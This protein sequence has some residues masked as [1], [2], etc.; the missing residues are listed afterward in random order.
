MS[1][2][3]NSI[4]VGQQIAPNFTDDIFA[5]FDPIYGIGGLREVADLTER[6]NISAERLRVGMLVYVTSE[7]QFYR[8]VSFS[9]NQNPPYN[10]LTNWENVI[11][12]N[13]NAQTIS[14]VK[15]F[16]SRPTV[17]GTG[18]LLSGEVAA[19][20]TT[21]V[22]TTGD[23]TIS[24]IKTLISPLSAPN[25][26]YN[27]GAQTISGTKTFASRPKVNGTGVLLSGEFVALPTTIVYTTGDQTI[28][29]VKTFDSRP[30]INGTGVL[31]SGENTVLPS[32]IVYTTGDQS[33]SGVKTFA[34]RPT[35]N[36][37]GVLLSGEAAVLPSTIVYTTGDQSISGVKTFAS[38]PTVNG[39]GVLLSGE[40]AVL[41]STIVYTTG[42]QS[43]SGAKTFIDKISL[44]GGGYI[45]GYAT[46]GGPGTEGGLLITSPTLGGSTEINII[47]GQGSINLS[48]DYGIGISHAGGINLTN[49]QSSIN[50]P[51]GGG[52]DLNGITTAKTGTF[53]KLYAGNLV[54]N[55]GDQ[56]I[57]GNKFF[58]NDITI[59]NLTVTGTRTIT[60]TQESNIQSNYLL[61]NITGGVTNGGIYFVTGAGFSGINSSGPIIAYDSDINKFRIGTGIRSTNINSLKTIAAVE[62][63]VTLVGNQT[64]SG[65]KTFSASHYYPYP[66]EPSSLGISIY[67]SGQGSIFG[68]L[69]KTNDILTIA[70]SNTN[71]KIHFDDESVYIEAGGG[72]PN[73]EV[74][75]NG[76]IFL[77]ASELI[78]LDGQTAGK[79]GTFE[80]LY[81]GNLVYNTGD[82][83][84]S[85]NKTFASRP[86]VNGTGFLLSGE[87]A[88]SNQIL[89]TTY[90]ILTGLKATN[91]LLSGQRYRISDF[92]LKWNNQSINDQTVKT[93]ASGE[94][95]IVTAL[96]NKEI[97]Y[98][99]QS[100][101]YP[102]DT[103]YY[104]INA[105]GSYSWG[106]INNNASIPNFKGWIYRRVDNLLDIDIAYDWRNITVNCCKPDVNSI[107]NYSGNYNYNYPYGLVFVKSTGDDSN[108]GK[109]YYSYVTGNSGNALTNTNFWNPVSNFVESGTYF[110]TDESYGFKSLWDFRLGSFCISLSPITGSR[111]QQ[112]TFTSV[113]TGLGLFKLKDVT[114]IKILGGCNNVI[115]GDGFNSNIIGTGFSFNTIKNTVSSNII[116]DNFNANTIGSNFNFNTIGNNFASN[117]TSSS[118]TQNTIGNSFAFNTISST[119]SSNFGDG[120]AHNTIGASFNFNSITTN[121]NANII[122]KYFGSNSIGHGFTNNNIR[123][124]FL[125]N[126]TMGSFSY[127]TIGDTFVGNTI[128]VGFNQNT[129]G[130]NAE[131]N[132]IGN[133]FSLNT[134]KNNFSNNTSESNFT[135]VNFLTGT[136][137]Y[138]PYNTTLFSNTANIKKIRYFNSN[139]QI[140]VTDPTL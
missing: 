46:D 41:P 52:I 79:T 112:P 56:N 139:D 33:I 81:E 94:P 14:G 65:V 135:N 32:T 3:P 59:N 23:Q 104:N 20:P 108:R 9:E 128:G 101:T 69:I 16:A 2:I 58:L 90:S 113:L 53:Q 118:F 1:Q 38:R 106:S 5:L 117:T 51:E 121:F 107:P 88:D 130:N 12:L 45:S 11:F 13:N 31:L 87:A 92:V 100:E 138:Q 83:T 37:T 116:R 47:Q 103:I 42:D 73:I 61:L 62:D 120:C 71:Q 140:V 35:V 15:T 84:I 102:Q 66:G 91:S 131:S 99:A 72:L 54:Y 22:Y 125:N 126:V 8:L 122:G 60:N 6:N 86:T 25:L 110:A 98:L 114:N 7:N 49:G 24:G 80:K 63:V 68:P 105:S 133:N 70:G 111:I 82:Q 4:N 44:L 18:F 95:L 127:S 19:L 119:Y 10:I 134:I 57:N 77:N 40:A 123:D 75:Y 129:I 48:N 132:V 85:G 96:S 26:V 34:S 21:I 93:A 76:S 39:T 55:T 28:S 29:G 115:I 89:N 74:N 50:L 124:S 137:V 64:V 136:H 78:N 36:G 17:N 30:T 27:T 97:S 43:I 109:L 67:P